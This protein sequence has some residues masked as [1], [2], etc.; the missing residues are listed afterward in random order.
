MLFRSAE[1]RLQ[2]EQVHVEAHELDP[3]AGEA[4][5]GT[6]LPAFVRGLPLLGRLFVR[7][8]FGLAAPEILHDPARA[9]AIHPVFELR[10][11]P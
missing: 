9:A 10:P 11:T 7:V 4:F 1:L 2:G 3:A 6:T 8:L 5:F